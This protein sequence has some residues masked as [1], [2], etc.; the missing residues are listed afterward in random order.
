MNSESTTTGV[1]PDSDDPVVVR[2]NRIDRLNKIASRT[3][4]GLYAI[5]VVSFFVGLWT[6]LTSPLHFISGATLIVGSVILA[7]SIVITYGV[8]AAR[9]EDAASAQRA[10]PTEHAS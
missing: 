3:G 1:T 10:A 8:R 7:P 4:Y 2:R 9:R 5:S 6:S